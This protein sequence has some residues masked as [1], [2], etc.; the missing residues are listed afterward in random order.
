MHW[1]RYLP[2]VMLAALALV[3]ALSIADTVHDPAAADGTATP[4]K[5]LI[6]IYQENV[7]FDHCFGTYPNVANKPGE[8]AF[9]ASARTPTIDGLGTTL[10]TANPNLSNPQRLSRSQ[11]H[12]CD[13]NHEYPAEQQ[14]ADHGAMDRF[15]E[16]TS[17]FTT[18]PP[19]PTTP[20]TVAQCTGQATGVNPNYAVMDYYDGNTVTALWNYAQRFAMSDNSFST[21]YGP[22]TPGALNLISGNTFGA[23]CA[24]GSTIN[25]PACPTPFSTNSMP[26]VPAAQGAGTVIGDPQP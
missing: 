8:P 22:S 6:V 15:V 7:S 20:E 24:N 12:T 10:L 2:A 3:P 17:A 21:G 13:Q 14:A 25:A 11:A 23:V 1:R 5:H 18:P 4:I 19:T 16:F 9:H 26:G